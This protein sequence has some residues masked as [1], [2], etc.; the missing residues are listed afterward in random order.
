MRNHLV[1]CLEKEE[2]SSFPHAR[3]TAAVYNNEEKQ[4][5]IQIHCACQLPE[6][7]EMVQCA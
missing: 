1:D 3:K 6:Y 4:L 7:G 2:I 5:I